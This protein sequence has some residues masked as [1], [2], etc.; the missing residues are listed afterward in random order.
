MV[1]VY[2][3]PGAI[4]APPLMDVSLF[5]FTLSGSPYETRQVVKK[6][7]ALQGYSLHVALS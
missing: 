3:I 7:H 4:T 6:P 5:Y 1:E 2:P